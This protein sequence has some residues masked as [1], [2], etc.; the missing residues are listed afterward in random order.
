MDSTSTSAPPTRYGATMLRRPGWFYYASG[1]GA[2]LRNVR[3]EEHSADRVRSAHASG[4]IVYVLPRAATADHLALTAVLNRHR[5]PLS[6]WAPGVISFFWQPVRRAWADVAHRVMSRWQ[7]GPA[8]DPVASGWM[9]RR[10]REGQAVTLFVEDERHPATPAL[11][12]LLDCADDLE[13][14]PQLLPVV[15]VWDRAPQHGH[16]TVQAFLAGATNPRG[17]W[18]QLGNLYLRSSEAFV[19]VGEPIDLNALRARVRPER[20]CGALQALLRRALHGEAHLV[21]GPRLMSRGV[22]RQ[23]VLDNPAMRGLAR[24]EAEALG[25][26]YRSVRDEMAKDFDAIAARFSWRVIRAL[27]VLLRP[28]WTRVFSG[29][30]VRDEDLERIR[31]AMRGGTAILVPCHKSH[32]DYVLLSWVFYEHD[33]IVP[34]VVAGMNLAIWPVSLVLRGAG[35]FFIKRSFSGERIFPAVFSRY[36]RELIGQ[37][38]PVEFFI[39]GG[40]TRSGKL[41]RPRIGVLGMVMQA[42]ELRRTGREVTLLPMS[43]AYEQVA[44]ERAYARELGGVAKEPETVGQLVR[45]RRVLRRRF[46]R[47]YL[48]VGTP[49]PCSE[50]VD[51]EDGRPPFSER[52]RSDNDEDLYRI[53]E[54]ILH[55]I[56]AVT[57]LLPTSLVALALLAHHRRAI[58][59][60]DLQARIERFSAHLE[61]RG[62]LRSASLERFDL[63][64]RQALDR[65]VRG[66]R[67]EGLDHSGERVWSI[68][69]DQRITLEFYKNQVLHFFA[70]MGLAA[71]SLRAR[72]EA[73]EHPDVLLPAFAGL[74]WT[75]RR[76][77]VL[78]P[79]RAASELLADGLED[80]RAHGALA[81]DSLEVR[82]A[83]H[84]GEVYGLLRPIV[85]TYALVLRD[86]PRL[87]EQ[88]L[89]RDAWIS[90][91]QSAGA[92]LAERGAVTRPE[93]LSLV[94]LKNAV[95]SYLEEGLLEDRGGR[96]LPDAPLCD[97]R[98]QM[99]APML[100]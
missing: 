49:I 99:L 72:T 39:E 66:G 40:R 92:E 80:L 54:R 100:D 86:T 57:V 18:A 73:P 11:Q 37:G 9:A 83:R 79:D 64:V 53:G 3:M 84:I 14:P 82:S 22:M 26:T 19:Q 34:H 45:A 47:V 71:C 43:L 94:S 75:L 10:I 20:Q 98:L 36:L 58:R 46:G 41:L 29:V 81:P 78:D 69:P 91:L 5:L 25:R 21:R 62:A 24:S 93:A 95:A 48:R 1:L 7:Q 15:V 16:P 70:P 8:P 88:P 42:A 33:L 6:V 17:L 50:L 28:L 77:L 23:V 12:A 44:E 85:E 61:R 31:Q 63:A 4:P 35:G 60:A 13:R 27:H 38:Y 89:D 67:I 55:R 96:L 56:G 51:G 65:F 30:D 97:E 87:V 74:L 59:H 52:P 76:E 32:F 2:R 68:R 90:L